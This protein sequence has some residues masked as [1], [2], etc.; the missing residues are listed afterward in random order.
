MTQLR[1]LRHSR[2]ARFG[3]LELALILLILVSLSFIA[4]R[5]S[6]Q[7]RH[8]GSRYSD[9]APKVQQEA[10]IANIAPT[11]NILVARWGETAQALMMRMPVISDPSWEDLAKSADVSAIRQPQTQVCQTL[12]APPHSS[13]SITVNGLAE[14]LAKNE[15]QFL[16]D[17]RAARCFRKGDDLQVFSYRYEGTEPY[18][19]HLG[20]VKVKDI[21][22][23]VLEKFP[24]EL[25]AALQLSDF[26]LIDILNYSNR[27]FEAPGTLVR[28][29]DFQAPGEGQVTE[30]T[31]EAAYRYQ[32]ADLST[33]R[34]EV[35]NIRRRHPD[36]KIFVI[37]VRSAKEFQDF[38]VPSTS[39]VQVLNL[40][41]TI[42]QFE[43]GGRRFR[44][45]A[46]GLEVARAQFDLS[47]MITVTSQHEGTRSVIVVVGADE[48]DGRAFWSLYAFHKADVD[49]VYW[50]RQGVNKLAN[51]LLELE[52]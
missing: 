16:F 24:K 39:R 32:I 42:P 29:G 5:V 47:K 37:D 14:K 40:P 3:G 41:F 34:A 25:Q 33:L 46:S 49:R 30:Q 48:F 52:K 1:H 21:L 11:D 6:S 38:S 17:T 7:G 36:Y 10:P 27:A 44:W 50:A 35:T 28:I 26:N 9:S 22:R 12:K 13:I 15:A 4:Y 8:F 43:Q 23:V 51:D 20:R 19:Q 45:N 2:R 31:P 18:V